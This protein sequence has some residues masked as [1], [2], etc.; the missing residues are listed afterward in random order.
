MKK[1][2]VLSYSLT[3]ASAEAYHQIICELKKKGY[4]V[5]LVGLISEIYFPVRK[6]AFQSYQKHGYE[7]VVLRDKENLEKII[8]KFKP[9]VFIADNE[10]SIAVE[11]YKACEEKNIPTIL[12]EHGLNLNP[13]ILYRLRFLSLIKRIG[14][15]ILHFMGKTSGSMS[16][17]LNFSICLYGGRNYQIYR[18]FGVAKQR[19]HDTGFPYFDLVKR[20]KTENVKNFKNKK[21]KNKKEKTVLFISSGISKYTNNQQDLDNFYNY[22]VEIAKEL[23][24]NC[25][26]FIRQKPGAEDFSKIS[27]S[28]KEK[29]IKFNI[30]FL[31]PGKASFVEITAYDLIAGDPSVVLLEAM[32]LKKPVIIF[33]YANLSHV[34]DFINEVWRKKL[35]T[36]VIRNVGEISNLSSRVFSDSYEERLKKNLKKYEKYLFCRLDGHAG[37]RVAEVII[38]SL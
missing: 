17:Q 5:R 26:F 22:V 21:D 1:I 36:I 3:Q 23:N 12:L 16:A 37:A 29:L 35:Q 34:T 6:F 15:R 38:K 20:A 31:P 24:N 11:L 7:T 28:M 9:S 8:S 25:R 4:S 27:S 14:N 10:R 13:G 32:I 30:S 19:L 18:N 2:I 33:Q